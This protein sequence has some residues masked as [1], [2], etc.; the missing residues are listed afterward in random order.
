MVPS[1]QVRI[2]L[3]ANYK[4]ISRGVMSQLTTF[5]WINTYKFKTNEESVLK[6][7]Q[8]LHI[9]FHTIKKLKPFLSSK[10]KLYEIDDWE[11][12]TQNGR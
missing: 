5:C 4:V 3:G 10:N 12:N 7:S 6:P 9:T 8:T 2:Y 11:I 1:F